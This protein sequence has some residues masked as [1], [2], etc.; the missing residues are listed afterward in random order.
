M[1]YLDQL[2]IATF[3]RYSVVFFIIKCKSLKIL[4]DLGFLNKLV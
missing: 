4:E 1:V 3:S 2:Q